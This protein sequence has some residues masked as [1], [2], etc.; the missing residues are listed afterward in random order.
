LLEKKAIPNDLNYEIDIYE[1]SNK[2]GGR[3]A[4]IRF[5]DKDYEAG[6]S[7]I[8]ERNRYAAQLLKKFG[9]FLNIF[10]PDF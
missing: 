2:I 10:I 8:H 1:K 4:T 6:G 9:N 3:V 5:E 7:I